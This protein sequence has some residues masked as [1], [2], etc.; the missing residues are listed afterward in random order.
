[1][2]PLPLGPGLDAPP[3]DGRVA[4]VEAPLL[5]PPAL[6][7]APLE[8]APGPAEPEEVVDDPDER[9]CPVLDRTFPA[10]PPWGAERGWVAED[11]GEVVAGGRALVDAVDSPGDDPAAEGPP[12]V[13]WCSIATL[14]PA[15]VPA[16]SNSDAATSPTLAELRRAAVATAKVAATSAARLRRATPDA[17]VRPLPRRR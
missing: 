6:L 12:I 10:A 9:G 8:L 7:D 16:A 2:P 1:M 4:V 17:A 11:G 5:L 15:A 13:G 14:R 3:I